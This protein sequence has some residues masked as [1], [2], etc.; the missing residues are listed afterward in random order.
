MKTTTV[1]KLPKCD[2]CHKPAKYDTPTYCGS[3][4]Y[5]CP[6]HFETHCVPNNIG[7]ELVERKQQSDQ[8]R[9]V[10]GTLQNTLEDILFD[11]LMEVECCN[12]GETKNLEPDACGQYK[13][14][15]GCDVTIPVL[16]M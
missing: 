8:N 12:C 13:C 7:K 9:L 16:P 14:G 5:V 10:K 11:G 1:E 3:W 2:F 6:T 4:A 15:C